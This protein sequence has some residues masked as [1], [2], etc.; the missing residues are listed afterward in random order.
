[1]QASYHRQ[2]LFSGWRDPGQAA[3]KAPAE[4]A[5]RRAR[6]GL[7]GGGAHRHQA[8]ALGSGMLLPLPYLAIS[9]NSPLF[10]CSV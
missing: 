8:I 6:W 4:D 1:M 5:E 2:R 3:I 7:A 10:K 9:A